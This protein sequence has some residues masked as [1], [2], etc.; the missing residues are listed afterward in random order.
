[1]AVGRKNEKTPADV[2]AKA[3]D[4]A[5]G[6]L[7]APRDGTALGPAQKPVGAL[8]LEAG[9]DAPANAHDAARGHPMTAQDRVANLFG[10]ES[11]IPDTGSI[12]DTELEASL[13]APMVMAGSPD[14]DIEFSRRSLGALA[15]AAQQLVKVSLSRLPDGCRA[16]DIE[17]AAV[18]IKA[19]ADV[20]KDLAALHIQ[21]QDSERKSSQGQIN[22]LNQGHIELTTAELLEKIS[23]GGI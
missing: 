23:D 6:S 15:M 19:A 20:A 16:S 9:M 18:S 11:V 13:P 5:H 4:A 3:L 8:E 7:G 10:V 14:G 21:I 17:A 2:P 1:M 12:I 22:I